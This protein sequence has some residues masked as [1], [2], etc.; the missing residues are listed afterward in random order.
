[1]KKIYFILS[2]FILAAIFTSCASGRGMAGGGCSVNAKL[3]GYR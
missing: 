3:V 2:V 1:M